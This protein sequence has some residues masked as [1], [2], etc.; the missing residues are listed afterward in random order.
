MNND[1]LA[2]RR[3]VFEQVPQTLRRSVHCE[4]ISGAGFG[5]RWHFHPELQ[6]TLIE[7]GTGYRL[8]G[9]NLRRFSAGDVVFLGPDLPH[10]WQADPSQS[11][12]EPLSA[13]IVQF[14]A[15]LLT[16]WS[17]ESAD[18][19]PLRRLLKRAGRGLELTGEL[20]TIAHDLLA[21]APK[22]SLLRR[23]VIVLDVLDRMTTSNESR[24]LC[25]P[26]FAPALDAMDEERVQ[27]V[28]DYLQRHLA[29]PIYLAE[30]ARVAHLSEGAFSRFFHSRTGRTFAQFVSELRIGRA[31]EL[32]ANTDQ[33]ITDI[34]WD[35]GFSNLS[36][37]NRQF[38][39]QQG[40]TPR[41][42][43]KSLA[44]RDGA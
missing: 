16:G 40:M 3:P 37:F 30:A 5:S 36:L 19:L 4:V 1:L 25:S 14:P 7:R 17:K 44:L 2:A 15:E 32:L 33:P 12:G 8:V 9:D 18:F 13:V 26:N 34:A 20:R 39:R 6:F 21:A 28:C 41:D 43:R 31:C 23:I 27:A 29:E 10:V 35:C 22:A 38:R 42:Y 11:A 24:T